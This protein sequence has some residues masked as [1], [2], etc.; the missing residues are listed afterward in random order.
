MPLGVLP[1]QAA[2]DELEL[3]VGPPNPDL[4]P[5]PGE[6][7]RRFAS[8]PLLYRPGRTLMCNTGAEV[9][10]VLIAR[11][12]A[13]PF[14]SFLAE[15]IFEPLGMVDTGFSVPAGKLDRLPPHDAPDPGTG[16][17]T[18][19]DDS[20]GRWSRPPAFPSGAGGL[21]ST[22]DDYLAFGQ[23]LLDHGRFGRERILCRPSVQAMI[24]D[25]LTADQRTAAEPFLGP[26]RSWGFGVSMVTRRDGV[27]EIPGQFG[28]DGGMGT[29]W[30]S[31][32]LEEMVVILMTTT[33]WTSPTPPP[34]FLD[35][36]TSPY[37]AID[38]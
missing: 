4:P 32:P 9:L 8:L 13:R 15:R 37:Q 28:W 30:T 11:A 38:D 3:S 25:Q 6:W 35:F 10:G 16:E 24:T 23:M 29:R 27:A 17:L 22:A 21:V 26:D 5:E 18:V 14:E 34:V 33:M 2:M 31:D 19:Y 7:M 20:A 1:I 12:S 36:R